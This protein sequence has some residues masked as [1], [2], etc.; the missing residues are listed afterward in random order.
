LD[1]I[2]WVLNPG[3]AGRSRTFGGPSCLLL[4]AGARVWR[5]ETHRFP[6]P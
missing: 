2:P 1:A 6:P 3:A 5:V 4:H